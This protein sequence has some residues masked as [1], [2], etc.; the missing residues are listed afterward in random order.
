LSTKKSSSFWDQ[1]EDKGEWVNFGDQIPID[2]VIENAEPAKVET[3][4]GD[5]YVIIVWQFPI[6]SL[7]GGLKKQLR[8]NAVRLQ[9]GLK[10]AS[11]QGVPVRGNGYRIT[12]SG[13]GWA[14]TYNVSFR[15]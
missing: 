6:D 5:A 9:R 1:V 15:G 7:V 3:N 8:I 12:R 4:W 11:P 14:T 13:E 2:I 10:L